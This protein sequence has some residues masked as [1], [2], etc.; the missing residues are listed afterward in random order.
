MVGACT[1]QQASEEWALCEFSS[2]MFNQTACRA[3]DINP[4]NAACLGCMFGALGQ[5]K[6]GAVLLL[7]DGQWI[8]NKAGC[9]ALI[10]GDTSETSC[11]AKTQAA[12]VCV[13]SSCLAA[14]VL[15]APDADFAAC[16]KASRSGTCSAYVNNAACAQLP[17]YASCFYASFR[18]Y[19]DAM[20][21]LFC[22]SGRPA[23]TAEGG[24]A[25][26]GP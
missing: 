3:F 12:D 10:D 11:G 25:G 17:S 20:V 7:P 19:Y 15:P 21:D 1:E 26:A 13:Y 22:V 16:E 6:V 8:A 23:S 24:A 5:A 4:A 9:I 14:C 18:E 2:G